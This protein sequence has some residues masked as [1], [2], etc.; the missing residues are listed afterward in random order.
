MLK[1]SSLKLLQQQNDQNV[2]LFPLGSF[3]D[4]DVNMHGYRTHA[5]YC[6]TY[7]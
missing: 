2:G 1:M 4:F 7:F 6:K 3:Y 5:I